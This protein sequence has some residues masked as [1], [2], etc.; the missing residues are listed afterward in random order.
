MLLPFSRSAASTGSIKQSSCKLASPIPQKYSKSLL[1]WPKQHENSDPPI[2]HF[3]HMCIYN[4]Q[5]LIWTPIIWTFQCFRQTQWLSQKSHIT[6]VFWFPMFW[7]A[8]WSGCSIFCTNWSLS[9]LLLCYFPPSQHQIISNAVCELHEGQE[10]NNPCQ[11]Q[12]I[13]KRNHIRQTP[14]D[15]TS[16]ETT[17]G[18]LGHVGFPSP[19]HFQKPLGHHVVLNVLWVLTFFSL[20]VVCAFWVFFLQHHLGP[21]RYCSTECSLEAKYNDDDSCLAN[22]F[23]C[24]K[25]GCGA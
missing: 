7:A 20:L 1:V 17:S 2:S 18:S 6:N 13:S 3:E 23:R 12:T 4:R 11:F 10:F 19:D 14:R 24:L 16:T 25:L 8:L 15:W 5:P 22:A 21:F 9:C